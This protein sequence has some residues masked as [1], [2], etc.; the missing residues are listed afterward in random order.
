VNETLEKS[1]RFALRPAFFD[2]LHGKLTVKFYVK[3][4]YIVVRKITQ[5]CTLGNVSI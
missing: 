1:N 3:S 2:C 4:H 5:R